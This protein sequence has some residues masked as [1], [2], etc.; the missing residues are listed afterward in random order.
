M[1][2]GEILGFHHV[3]VPVSNLE[4]S[5]AWY[6]RVFDLKPN[7]EFRDKDDVVRGVAYQ[8]KNGFTL[9]LR[10]NS[11]LAQTMKGFDPLAV[12]VEGRADID[13][14]VERLDELRVD[15]SPVTEGRSAG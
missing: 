15:H 2:I 4:V 7:I 14:W 13:A 1:A 6:E 9:S 8:P 3:K 11:K 10:Q 12:L 5:R